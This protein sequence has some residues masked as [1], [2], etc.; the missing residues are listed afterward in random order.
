VSASLAKYEAVRGIR[1]ERVSGKRGHQEREG[2][3]KERA[4]GKRGHQE[5]EGNRIEKGGHQKTGKDI[6][7]KG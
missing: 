5:R 6:E 7:C 4:P 2:I 1:K 3:R